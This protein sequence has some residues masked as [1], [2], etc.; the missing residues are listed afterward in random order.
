MESKRINLMLV[1]DHQIMIDGIKALLKNER[2]FSIIAETTKP[3]T[4]LDLMGKKMPEIV[5]ADISMPELNGI[6]LTKLIN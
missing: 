2:E 4:V 1:D 5:I 6:E 3:L